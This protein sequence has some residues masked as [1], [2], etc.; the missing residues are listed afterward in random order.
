LNYEQTFSH[1]TTGA[2][3]SAIDP[4]SDFTSSTTVTRNQ[5]L[6]NKL[7]KTNFPLFYP[8]KTWS[9]APK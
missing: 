1:R 3:P 6:N 7:K 8:L 9:T 2:K 5:S 4:T